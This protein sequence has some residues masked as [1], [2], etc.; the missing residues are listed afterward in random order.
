MA[1]KLDKLKALRQEAAPKL[2]KVLN[3]DQYA[4]L[5]RDFNQWLDQLKQRLLE[6][7]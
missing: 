6:Q 1:E 5:E 3:A 7:K 2:M 4:K